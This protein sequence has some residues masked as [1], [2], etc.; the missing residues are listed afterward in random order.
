MT[1]FP[2]PLPSDLLPSGGHGPFR[3]ALVAPILLFV[4]LAVI[5]FGLSGHAVPIDYPADDAVLPA[6]EAVQNE[7]AP[8]VG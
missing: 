7:P 8:C 4:T 1:R 5:V 3:A 6:S 2:P